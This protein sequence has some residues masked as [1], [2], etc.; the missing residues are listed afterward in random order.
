MAPS[1]R[2]EMNTVAERTRGDRWGEVVGREETLGSWGKS[3]VIAS[4]LRDSGEDLTKLK[5]TR[6]SFKMKQ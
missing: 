4:S 3:E 6:E 5:K 1:R 2:A